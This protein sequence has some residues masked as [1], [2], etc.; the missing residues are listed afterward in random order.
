MSYNIDLL[1]HQ[2]NLHT[3]HFNQE[4][5]LYDAKTCLPVYVPEIWNTCHSCNCFDVLTM[6]SVLK[7]YSI[8]IKEIYK[9]Q[10]T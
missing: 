8:Y 4:I 7:K 3:I 2:M 6:Y 10:H 5:R 1:S 9:T